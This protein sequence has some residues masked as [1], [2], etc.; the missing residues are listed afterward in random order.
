MHCGKRRNGLLRSDAA[1]AALLTKKAFASVRRRPGC[2]LMAAAW[3]MDV[4]PPAEPKVGHA[5]TP[6]YRPLSAAVQEA[7]H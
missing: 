5:F 7:L 4:G 3:V 1:A 6:P 2:T